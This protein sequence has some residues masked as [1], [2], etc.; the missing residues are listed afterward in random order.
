MIGGAYDGIVG[1]GRARVPP[2]RRDGCVGRSRG[3]GGTG[4]DASG[5]DRGVDDVSHRPGSIEG[6]DRLHQRRVQ[7]T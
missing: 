3:C 1:N 4:S 6:A 2:L 5:I 7:L